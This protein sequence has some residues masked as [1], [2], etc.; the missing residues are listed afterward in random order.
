MELTVYT[1]GGEKTSRTIVLDDQ[2]F[3]ITPNDHAIWLDTKLILA[4]KRQG[5]HD[6]LERNEVAGS[7]RKVK[8]QKGTGTARVGNI[9]SPTIRG[10]GRAFG[11][12]PRDYGFKLN[13]KVKRLA[14]MSALTYKAKDD[15]ILVVEDFSFESPKTKQMVGMLKALALQD[16]KVLVV[17]KEVDPVLVL[18][19]RNLQRAKVTRASDINTYDILNAGKLLFTEGGLRELEGMFAGQESKVS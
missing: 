15:G 14:R 12:H 6:S 4:N 9:K 11:P 17:T 18:S 8:R 2:I 7:S 16:R 5:T 1:I 13:K 10:G 3:N 19:T